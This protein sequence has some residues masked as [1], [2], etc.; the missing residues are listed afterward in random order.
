MGRISN[1]LSKFFLFFGLLLFSLVSHTIYAWSIGLV[2]I[3][4]FVIIE[5]ISLKNKAIF[6]SF[7]LFFILLIA[8]VRFQIDLIDKVLPIF[9]I[10]FWGNASVFC[11]CILVW[12]F[13]RSILLD[14][15]NKL[16][17]RILPIILWL[18]IIAFYV[19]S[20]LFLLT[21]YYL[22]FVEPFTGIKSRF[23]TFVNSTIS[24]IG[25]FR[26]TG[27]M[28]EP[29]TYFFVVLV[30]ASLI[31]INKGFQRNRIVLILTIISMYLSFS[32]AAVIIATVFIIYL[33]LILR[34]RIFYYFILLFLGLGIFFFIGSSI[35]Q[36]FL[37]QQ[38]KYVETSDLRENL[39]L[40]VINREL[41]D[42]IFAYGPFAV[43]KE[44]A[45]SSTGGG[46]NSIA[47]LNDAGVLIFLWLE[48][49]YLGILI[50]VLMC[51]RQKK[52]GLKHVLLF[53]IISF[54]KINPFSPFFI[55]FWGVSI[56][57]E[58][59]EK[60]DKLSPALA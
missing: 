55:I 12:L 50:F 52:I 39:V 23:D 56:L 48:F 59:N 40:M 27:F 29:S 32:T 8:I 53:L 57:S 36:L 24:G 26:P 3:I 30:L 49:G 17:I 4:F 11:L 60:K 10:S 6:E 1:I 7:L 41:D 38:D 58:R 51:Y 33:F 31:V 34:V 20:I 22:D 28:A 43:D 19:Q 2:C 15:K 14:N 42:A 16:I 35:F 21:G 45:R 46:D 47:S 18:H 5:K 54:T 9:S 44:I 13:F 37:F 25:S